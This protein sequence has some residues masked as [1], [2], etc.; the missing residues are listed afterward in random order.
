MSLYP[1]S[2]TWDTKYV[3]VSNTWATKDT[4]TSYLKKYTLCSGVMFQ[5]IQIVFQSLSLKEICQQRMSWK[6]GKCREEEKENVFFVD[7]RNANEI[8]GSGF[9]LADL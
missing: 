8:S 4:V 7:E 3:T 2:N 9:S 6:K 5:L 1:L